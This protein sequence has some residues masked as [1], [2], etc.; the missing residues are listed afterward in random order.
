MRLTAKA[1][2]KLL[3]LF[4]KN[5]TIQDDVCIVWHL[6]SKKYQAQVRALGPLVYVMASRDNRFKWILTAPLLAHE[7]CHIEQAEDWLHPIRY[8]F[9]REYRF[10]CE[11]TAY[12]MQLAHYTDPEIRRSNARTFA[13][14]LHDNY[15]LKKLP[16]PD[17][18]A[19]RLIRLSHKVGNLA[20]TM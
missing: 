1:A 11:E 13:G 16:A 17:V 20:K 18:L 7:K 6:D 3:R 10:E 12:A 14:Y 4:Y 8:K 2:K 5:V 9:D 15:D 19:A